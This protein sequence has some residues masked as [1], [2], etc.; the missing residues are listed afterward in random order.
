M[1]INLGDV[2]RFKYL[3]HKVM[4]LVYDESLSYYEFLC[5][6]IAKLNE[7]IDNENEQNS[8]IED[9]SVDMDNWTQSAIERYNQF[10]SEI[11]EMIAAFETTVT[12]RQSAFE[13]AITG[14]QNTFETSITEMANEFVDE[15]NERATDFEDTIT[16]EWE[17]FL[18]NYLVTLGVV[19]STGSSTTDVMSQK[20]VT[21][22]LMERVSFTEGQN[23]TET[24]KRTARINIG[25]PAD[26]VEDNYQSVVDSG[27]GELIV[28]G[29]EDINN[30]SVE[31]NAT[32]LTIQGINMCAARLGNI[33]SY[34]VT[35]RNNG[36]Q[37]WTV[38]GTASSGAY[39]YLTETS[40]VGNN[41]LFDLNGTY[42][43]NGEVVS[44]SISAGEGTGDTGANLTVR[45]ASTTTALLGGSFN[46]ASQSFA[47]PTKAVNATSCV[48]AFQ[49]RQGCVYNNFTFRV[50]LNKGGLM[51]WEEY[52]TP[53]VVN[54]PFDTA[55]S[56]A[57]TFVPNVWFKANDSST[58]ISVGEVVPRFDVLENRI[59]DIDDE[60]DIINSTLNDGATM[61]NKLQYNGH[62]VAVNHRGYRTGYPENT[63][64]AFAQSKLKGFNC[65]ETDVRLTSDGVA[66]LLHNETINEVARNGD[67][68]TIDGS[69]YIANITYAQA[70]TYDFGIAKGDKFAGTKICRLEDCI[71]FCKKVG[72]NINLDLKV[73]G[74]GT[75]AA[76]MV[77]SY[78]MEDNVDFGGFNENVLREVLA[79]LPNATV[80]M[81]TT[82]DPT[83]AF[84]NR[85]IALKNGTNKV[86]IA[87][88]RNKDI[89]G[90]KQLLIDNDIGYGVFTANSW[91]D[92][93][94]VDLYC[95][96]FTTE[97]I[98][99]A[100]R[101]AN[102][103][104]EEW[105]I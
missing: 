104:L 22:E 75:V 4:P 72:L 45:T 100:N 67:G 49:L 18:N 96:K 60:I 78:A 12:N 3:A 13:T 20:A 71:A 62:M 53:V 38:N 87:F 35:F 31:G 41:Y 34:G 89:S 95:S 99:V 64:W 48:V 9:M 84:V 42:T 98:L 19:Q 52:K 54:S 90:V 32:E 103:A 26:I 105:T 28:Y 74:T 86:R 83:T 97:G 82:G 7:V 24:E 81:G 51:P 94:S 102:E 21:D 70:L 10:T 29:K 8:A 11:D 73:I 2:S 16:G 59:D 88:D 17:N 55:T 30:V 80:G 37:T 93:E 50:M 39:Y 57:N 43:L 25:I 40:R 6:V 61:I 68:T 63:L 23:L 14:Q 1:A 15:M 56:I 33:S 58:I 91:A 85:V 66:V 69:V 76:N 77:K 27:T 47:H 36:D 92:I 101:Y 46:I 5:K 65:I 44:G 79:V